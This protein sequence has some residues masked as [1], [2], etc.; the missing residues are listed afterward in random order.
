MFSVRPPFFIR[1]FDGKYL[2]C[3]FP[4]ADK[5]IY[6]SFDDGP[7]P[8]VT[9]GVLGILEERNISATFFCVGENVRK[10]PELLARISGSGHALGNHTFHHLNGWTTP[11]AEYFEDVR[12]CEAYFRSDLFRP[13]YGRMTPSQF[14]LIRKNYRIILWSVLSGDYNRGITKEKCLENVLTHTKPGS[15]VVFHDS[16]KAQE[17]L[18]YTLPR[19]LDHFLGEGYRF[20]K[21]NERTRSDLAK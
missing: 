8:E 13:P 4:A 21:I 19:F 15:I 7:V 12:R 11:P 17:N 5:I 16:L 14:F 9:P 20:E 2:A 1:I 18:F 10:Y 3:S 6:L